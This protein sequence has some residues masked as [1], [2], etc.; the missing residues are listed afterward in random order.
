MLTAAKQPEAVRRSLVIW[1]LLD[2][3]PGHENQTLGLLRALERLAAERG[4]AVPQCIKLFVADQNFSLWSFV[5]RRF[6]LGKNLPVPDFIIGAGHRTHWPMLCARRAF[7]GKAIA[8]MSPSLPCAF[9]DLVVA[10]AHDGLTGRN[11]IVTQG[12][13]NVMQPG[14]KAPGKTL[15]MVGGESK[16]FAWSNE[17]VLLQLKEL[18]TRYP[19]LAS[20]FADRYMPWEKCPTGWLANE[21][22]GAENAWVTEDSVSMIYEALSAGC[23]IGLLGLSEA[24]GRL[25]Q[26]IV[27]LREAKRVVRWLPSTAMP[28]LLLTTQA[29]AESDR[30]AHALLG[31]VRA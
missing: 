1:R 4:Q 18:A 30:V 23:R 20:F 3:K 19:A 15:V 31:A 12:V 16:H 14:E 24:K 28:E 17:Q 6:H 25:A 13:L 11:V 29:L 22:A 5:L 27:S 9:F 21:L 26:G 2:G 8:L 7:G 10:P